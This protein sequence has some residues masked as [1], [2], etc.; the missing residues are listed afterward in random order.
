V[1]RR[2]FSSPGSILDMYGTSMR[3]R[4]RAW[5]AIRLRGFRAFWG[6]TVLVQEQ[7]SPFSGGGTPPLVG[8]NG[9]RDKLSI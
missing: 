9:G 8:M 4:P 7:L 3:F 2:V 1:C 5:F 6:T